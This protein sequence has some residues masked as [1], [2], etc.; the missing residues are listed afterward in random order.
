M[1]LLKTHKRRTRLSELAYVGLNAGLALA[2]LAIV[3]GI[4]S[5]WPAFALVLLSKW[6][7]LA[8][9]PRFWFANLIANMVDIVVGISTVIFLYGASGVLWLQVAITGLYIIW[10]LVIKPRSSRRYVAI[11]AGT[12]VFT[13]IT[14]LSIV[15]FTWDI[16]FFVIGMWIIGYTSVRHVL[17]SYDEP[18]TSIYSLAGGLLF[19]EFGWIAF[20]WLMAYPIPGFGHIQFSQLALLTTLYC[21][22]AER[23]YD[24]YHKHGVVRRA[25]VILPIALTVG[26][27]IAVYVLAVING[28]DAL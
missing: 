6:R 21:L 15:S 22:V 13:G 24:S 5:S 28:S 19:A 17:G 16:A 1:D 7:A 27:M 8:V 25:D 18:F 11:Q 3:L 12:A 20:H 26:V 9:R 10:L 2:L 14:A 23:A 4:Q